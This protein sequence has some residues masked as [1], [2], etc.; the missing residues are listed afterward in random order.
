MP[1]F[2]DRRQATAHRG[3]PVHRFIRLVGES[4][5]VDWCAIGALQSTAFGAV[6]EVGGGGHALCGGS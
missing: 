3:R 5:L 6:L 1:L 2:S 4:C